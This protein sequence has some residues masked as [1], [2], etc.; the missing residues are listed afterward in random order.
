MGRKKTNYTFN[1]VPKS[2]EDVTLA[3]YMK[4]MEAFKE[5]D[6][7]LKTLAAIANVEEKE[8]KEAPVFVGERLM[9]EC[10][11]INTPIDNTP[12]SQI[13]IDG[14]VYKMGNEQELKFGEWVDVQT[15]LDENDG[16]MPVILAILCRK[17]GER[18]DNDFKINKLEKR[19]RMFENQPI[20]KVY[21]LLT[22][23]LLSAMMS[24][25][26]MNEYSNQAKEQASLILKQLENLE[27]DGD[28]LGHYTNSQ[29][30]TLQK[31]KQYLNSI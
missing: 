23:F 2:W 14:E 17:E 16:N 30:R 28:G 10:S 15:I 7:K 29:M 5:E 24:P 31:L 1:N 27:G 21:P 19:I 3:H 18:F 13:T 20:T 9:K 12:M 11:F 6:N 25:S 8:L 22:F 26:I 4:I